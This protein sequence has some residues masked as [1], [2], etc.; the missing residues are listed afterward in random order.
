MASKLTIKVKNILSKKYKLKTG[1]SLVFLQTHEDNLFYLKSK[2]LNL[3][4]YGKTLSISIK[5]MREEI[6]SLYDELQSDDNFSPEYLKIKSYL[7]KVIGF[8]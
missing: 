3:F 8:R 1:K 4:S 7:N 2:K 5:M 6:E